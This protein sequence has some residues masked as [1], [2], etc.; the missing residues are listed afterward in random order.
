MAD[1]GRVLAVTTHTVGDQV[2][3]AHAAGVTVLQLDESSEFPTGG[4]T[5]S[6]PLGLLT[7]TSVDPETD[8]MTLTTGLPTGGLAD[9]ARIELWDTDRGAVVTEVVASV[10][11]E[12]DEDDGDPYEATVPQN[13]RA[14]L[15]DDMPDDD[16]PLV[17][18][19]VEGEAVTDVPGRTPKL[20][21]QVVWNPHSYRTFNGQTISTATHEKLTGWTDVE[22]DG[23]GFATNG[24]VALSQ[25][26]Y[27][28][29]AWVTWAANS[30]GRRRIRFLVNGNI[31]RIRPD[32]A[33]PDIETYQEASHQMRLFEGDRVEV[34]VFQ[35]SGAGLQVTG[36]SFSIH[37]LSI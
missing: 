27:E 22:T 1:F 13:L 3:G 21:G 2:V 24:W 8:T 19:D 32:P 25:A 28:M 31:V 29:T 37:R 7:Y 34:W 35:T 18:I 36:G 15:S 12:G 17:E 30:T 16:G 23:V 14:Y 33:D 9:E 6:T 26:W 5:V 20:D 4:G 10:R 11:L